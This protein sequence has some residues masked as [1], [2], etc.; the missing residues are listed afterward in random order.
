MEIQHVQQLFTDKTTATSTPSPTSC[1]APDADGLVEASTP[2]VSSPKFTTAASTA[3]SAED[4]PD[5]KSPPRALT[6]CLG[7][8]TDAPTSASAVTAVQ[9][10]PSTSSM[11]DVTT[12][13]PEHAAA[14]LSTIDDVAKVVTTAMPTRCSTPGRG[15]DARV[16]APM[17]D[18]DT[19]PTPLTA[20][21]TLVMD[22][23]RDFYIDGDSYVSHYAHDATRESDENA[24]H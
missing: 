8:D 1:A 16:P 24:G 9:T 17:S 23:G 4:I 22:K 7:H 2:A 3:L 13:N 21:C 19:T 14:P 15:C 20:T 12:S 6:L 11:R 5:T 18:P 10:S